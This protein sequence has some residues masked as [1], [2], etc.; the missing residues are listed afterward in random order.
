MNSPGK[1]A[2]SMFH[3]D[4]PSLSGV[5]ARN[6]Y[7]MLGW[8]AFGV[9][10]PI[11]WSFDLYQFYPIRVI[12][13]PIFP[14]FE[15]QCHKPDQTSLYFPSSLVNVPLLV[16]RKLIRRASH[17]NSHGFLRHF[18]PE[19][20]PW[21]PAFWEWFSS[22]CSSSLL[23]GKSVGLYPVSPTLGPPTVDALATHRSPWRRPVR[24]DTAHRREP[25]ARM[26]RDRRLWWMIVPDCDYDKFY[27]AIGI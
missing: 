20:K 13:A 17:A 11:W 25:S 23:F 9:T 22:G 2:G 10:L 6:A 27:M 1:C 3:W 12:W 19:S 14:S 26:A 8:L 21:Y 16:G 24:S 7:F 5:M 18:D 15:A 4:S